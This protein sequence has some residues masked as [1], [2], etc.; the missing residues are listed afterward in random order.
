LVFNVG[1]VATVANP[2]QKEANLV[3]VSP[4]EIQAVMQ[5]T[6]KEWTDI[7]E[8]YPFSSIPIMNPPI[9]LNGV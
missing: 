8:P 1:G 6:R 4:K 7:A 2:C 3:M 5:A 9:P